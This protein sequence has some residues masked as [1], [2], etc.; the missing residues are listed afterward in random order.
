MYMLKFYHSLSQKI[1]LIFSE[2]VRTFHLDVSDIDQLRKYM[3]MAQQAGL[4]I[5]EASLSTERYQVVHNV[6]KEL[7]DPTYLKKNVFHLMDQNRLYLG[8]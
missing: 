5:L 2:L 7:I 8:K 3:E 4:V 6:N 1:L